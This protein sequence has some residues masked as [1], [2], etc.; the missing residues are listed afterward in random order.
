MVEGYVATE[1]QS[2]GGR[3]QLDA[4][5]TA[6]RLVRAEAR[7]QADRYRDLAMPAV[8]FPRKLCPWLN[9]AGDRR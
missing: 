1:R 8:W 2:M 5:R 9:D 7:G 4:G 6:A 3:Q